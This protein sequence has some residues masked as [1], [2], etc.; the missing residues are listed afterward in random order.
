MSIE[1][2]A[3]AFLSVI[4][5]LCLRLTA[6]HNYGLSLDEFMPSFQAEIFRGGNLMA[7]LKDG[8]FAIRSALQPFFVYVDEKHQLWAQHY[9]PVHAAIIAIF[10]RG[11]DVA[12]AHAVLT[13]ITVFALADIARQLFPQKPG[14]PALAALLLLASPQ[15]LLTAASGFAY[16]MHLA[17]NTA[18]LA[19]FLRGRWITHVVA[20]IVGF[21]ALGIHQ[22]HVHAIYVFPF[23]FAML[24]G[25]FGS[26]LMALPYVFAYA[27]G[28][29]VWI[30]WPELATYLQTGDP[31]VLPKA[32]LEIEYLANYLNYSDQ[33][34]PIDSQYSWLFLAVNLWRFLLWL[35]PAVVLLAILAMYS[36]SRLGVVASV[37]AIGVLFTVFASQVLLPNQMHTIG[38]RYYHPVIANVIIVAL[39]AYYAFHDQV[40]LRRTVAVLVVLGLVVFLPWRAFQIHEKVGPRAAIQTRLAALDTENVF[41]IRSGGAWFMADFIRNDP[42][43]QQSPRYLDLGVDASALQTTGRSI[44]ITGADLVE[45]GL[46]RGT[47]LEPAFDFDP[48]DP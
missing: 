48:P 28:I 30:M 31:S 37:S 40:R 21:F 11:I 12:L 8:D 22:V 45:M 41:F 24:L 46:P 33:I 29:P 18:W 27:V 34:G 14:A 9:R 42:Y 32:L 5:A 44:T 38:S 26:R 17:L 7:P 36:G 47:F 4:I 3:L 2:A 19:L 10:P 16:T 25:Y 23:G 20:A 39:A 43:L 6:H 35:S 15:V 13:G 1:R